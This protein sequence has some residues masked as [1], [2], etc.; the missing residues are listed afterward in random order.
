VLT[1][2]DSIGRRPE[3][4]AF[5]ARLI[6]V[7]T[8]LAT[9]VVVAG[10]FFMRV[11]MRAAR[12]N[13]N[14][15]LAAIADLKA[16]QIAEWREERLGEGRFL[17]RAPHTGADIASF[18]DR[19]NDRAA[20][21][22]VLDWLVPIK[23]GDRYAEVLL[24]DAAGRL[25]LVVPESSQPLPRTPAHSQPLTLAPEVALGEL[26]PNPHGRGIR[27]DMQVPISDSGKP[28]A[29]LLFLID[30]ANHL[31]PLLRAWPAPSQTA[32]TFLVRRDGDDVLFLNDVRHQPDTGLRLR[33]PISA[34]LL[35]AARAARGELG[36]NVGI[37]YR[38]VSVLATAR[39]LPNSTWVL[40]A[41]VDETEIYAPIRMDAARSGLLLGLIVLTIALAA[42]HLWRERTAATLTR[43]LVAE[44]E[45]AAG[46]ERLA[47]VMRYANDIV[48]LFDDDGHI[49]EA[50]ER[51]GEAYGYTRAELLSLTVTDLRADRNT[52][53]FRARLN[54][55]RSSR[56][57]RFESEHRRK[58]GS[59]FPVEISARAEQ[60][61][62]STLFLCIV[63][64][65]T[66]RRTHERQVERLNR[67]YAALSQVNHE[68]VRASRRESLLAGV[69][70]AIV[71][72]GGFSMCWA[73]ALDEATKGLRVVADFGD[74]SGYLKSVRVT[75]DD[76]P[77]AQGPIGTAIRENRP[78]VCADV[79]TES[80]MAPWREEAER[81]GYRSI[82]ALP[83]RLGANERG[84]LC[85]YARQPESFRAEE[86]ALL[87]KT[88]ADTEFGLEALRQKEQREQ[89]EDAL[90]ESEQRLRR[91]LVDSPFPTLVHAEDGEILEVSRS[92]TEITGYSR[93]ELKTIADWTELAYGRRK[94]PVQTE[95]QGLYDLTG[96]V[97]EGD[98]TIRTKGGGS[99]IWEFSSGPLGVASDGRRLVISMALD[100]TERRLAEAELEKQEELL[101]KLTDQ[102]PGVLYQY[103]LYPDGRS[104]FPIASAG[105]KDIYGVTPEEV[106]EDATPVFGR[107][108]PDDVDSVAASIQESAR[109]LELYHGE[110]R[111][112]LPEQGVRWR[113]CDAKPER[114]DDGGTLWYGIITDIT[115]RKAAEQK[116]AEQIEAIRASNEELTRFN[117]TM[118]DR[119]LRM[120]ELKQKLNVLH[121]RLGEAPPYATPAGALPPAPPRA[122]T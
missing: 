29:T 65:C 114:M 13:A 22:R 117:R 84:T 70:R 102:V 78:D 81:C 122:T 103:R 7:S 109:T 53:A 41:K 54:D 50:N 96:R 116:L 8:V 48:V 104:C 121:V 39:R 118:V 2:E 61:E 67:L 37:D 113:L 18:L 82:V 15:E 58:D 76:E 16:A 74:G 51:A 64:D 34:P 119:E 5:A 75:A 19:P 44:R 49:R 105:I 63:R 26:H 79:L 71:E 17:Q 80:R 73:G 38:G 23:G 20:R 24:F 3:D 60:T 32:E 28:V 97:R 40:L 91:A 110:F 88:V 55:M 46:A 11:E 107:L 33:H 45:Q 86:V 120:I 47:M 59:T 27:M 14:R 52:D 87:E 101:T 68:M 1:F 12:E 83:L 31:Y 85:V 72:Y 98:F 62:G 30:P 69:C 21:A 106:R 43:A 112:V 92:W 93:S 77:T 90:R 108:H 100:V 35:P 36:P 66:E 10:I 94:E 95:I 111:V 89:A 115:E 57:V 99:R 42:V 56:G 4:R 6:A 25:R 9:V